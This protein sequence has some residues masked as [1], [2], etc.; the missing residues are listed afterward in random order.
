ML[1]YTQSLRS[2][3]RLGLIALNVALLAVLCLIQFGPQAEAQV[4]PRGSYAMA[5]GRANGSQ[6][7][8]VYVVDTT[9]QELIAVTW[10]P[11]QKQITGVGYRNLVRDANSLTTGNRGR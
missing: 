3:R 9:T 11:N 1:R 5:A 4:R 8:V 6:S 2:P 7:G 10:D